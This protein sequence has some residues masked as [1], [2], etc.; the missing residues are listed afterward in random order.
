RWLK[1]YD[2]K[3]DRL[4]V[5]RCLA[6]ANLVNGDLLQILPSISA[7]EIDDRVKSKISLA[8]LELLVPLTWPIEK[9]DTQMTVNHHRH[10]PY[11]QQAQL[12]YKRGILNDDH[13]QLLRAAVR[14]VLPSMSMP[15]AERSSRDEGIIKL[16]LYFLRNVAV[17]SPPPTTRVDADENNATRSDTIKAFQKQDIFDL[18]LTV[19]SGIGEDFTVQDVVMLELL[20]HLMRGINTEQLYMEDIQVQEKAGKELSMLLSK[21]ASLMQDSKR[22]APTRHNK[23]G[24]MIWV[25]RDDHRYSTV[26]GQDVILNDRKILERLDQTKKWKRPRGKN[27]VPTQAQD[28]FDTPIRLTHEARKNLRNFVE[29]F[30]DSGFNPLFTS[31]QK[32]IQREADRVLDI[33][34]RQ[35]YFLISWFLRA[36]KHRRAAAKAASQRVDVDEDSY[37]GIGGIL[38]QES[39]ITLN[40]FM[41]ESYDNKEWQDLNAG[42][43]C[44]TQIL[45]TVQDMA[46]S[47]VEDHRMV[48]ENIQSRIFYEETTHDRI[49][50]I[51]RNYSNQGF[52][53]LDACTELAHVYLRSLEHY[54]KQNV[55][56][57]VRSKRRAR[58]QKKAAAALEGAETADNQD[59]GEEAARLDEVEDA[60][61]EEQVAR[62]QVTSKE[63]KFDFNRFASKFTSQA[64][65]NTFVE[66]T[67]FYQDL[68]V[69]QLKRAHRFFHRVAFKMDLAVMLYRVDIIALLTKVV[70][71]P[72]GLDVKRSDYREWEELVRRLIRKMVRKI[73]E[74]PELAVELLFSKISPTVYFLEHGFEKQT[75]TRTHREVEIAGANIGMRDDDDDDDINDE[76][77]DFLF[78]EGGPTMSKT[79]AIQD[80]KSKRRKR[81]RDEGDGPT[82][83]E[84]EA[85]AKSRQRANLEKRRKIKSDLFIHDSDDES[86]AGKDEAFFA[87]EDKRREAYDRK[88]LQ[89]LQQGTSPRPGS[90][91]KK[92]N[93]SMA[94]EDGSRKARR[95]SPLSD[96][97]NEDAN[98]SFSTPPRPGS[99][100]FDSSPETWAE[101]SNHRLDSAGDMYGAASTSASSPINSAGLKDTDMTAVTIDPGPSGEDEDEMP[102][103]FARRRMRAGFI[104]DSDS[105]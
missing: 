38:T 81:K 44:F 39:F 83:E 6:E 9:T 16:L 47:S 49:V 8:C 30:L 51:V 64:C 62:A 53:Y 31:V 25:K 13:H 93:A 104:I 58:K 68:T 80:L 50:S 48:A 29:E 33:H 69:N 15:L 10:I 35:F 74:R 63:R 94:S 57:Q 26:S 22:S 72:G 7:Q 55:E 70:Q 21:E 18:L 78:P 85:R 54:S 71:G 19:C 23:F 61:E 90:Q 24:T 97:E 12:I 67:K 32:A 75:V 77:D 96:G 56:M 82:A 40:R 105:E 1:L 43:K 27:T 41:Q 95:T 98:L 36:D 3:L 60:E 37:S 28:D 52:G 66:L 2:E 14:I 79:E 101:S 88:V 73:E 102:V 34:R 59:D 5:A 91:G 76:D 84:L 17:I 65:V 103:A 11:L 4:D 42:M 89:A 99:H 20:F 87:Q 86:D 45:L 46:E 100:N 92:R